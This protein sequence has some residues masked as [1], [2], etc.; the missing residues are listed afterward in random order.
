MISP[1]YFR[2]VEV[3]AGQCD[4]S[5]V[6]ERIEAEGA[7]RLDGQLVGEGQAGRVESS[8][9]ESEATDVGHRLQLEGAVRLDLKAGQLGGRGRV[10]PGE[11]TCAV[12]IQSPRIGEGL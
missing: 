12:E 3:G 2:G 4:L 8:P 9:R 11:K 6:G 7:V 5:G 10:R 1:G